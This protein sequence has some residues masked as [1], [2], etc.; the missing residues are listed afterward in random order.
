MNCTINDDDNNNSDELSQ[1]DYL[2]NTYDH[3][4]MLDT[5]DDDTK[6][7]TP[8]RLHLPISNQLDHTCSASTTLHEPLPV[9]MHSLSSGKSDA[10]H[11]RKYPVIF[12]LRSN[13]EQNQ[14]SQRKVVPIHEFTID[15]IRTI[16]ST[17]RHD[18]RNFDFCDDSHSVSSNPSLWNIATQQGTMKQNPWSYPNLDV[19]FYHPD[20]PANHSCDLPRTFVPKKP[21][22]TMHPIMQSP[23]SLQTETKRHRYHRTDSMAVVS[24]IQNNPTV[25]S[26]ANTNKK[27]ATVYSKHKSN[28]RESIAYRA[29]TSNETLLLDVQKLLDTPE[30]AAP[31]NINPLLLPLSPYNYFF[32]DERDNIVHGITNDNNEA[33]LPVPVSDFSD[34]KLQQLLYQHWFI[35]PTKQKRVHRKEHGKIKFERSVIRIV[36]STNGIVIILFLTIFR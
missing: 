14:Y 2:T 8:T 18:D 13:F 36:S 25:S 16:D 23:S 34:S 33:V 26:K 29:T 10:V 12:N 1:W 28:K 4:P 6:F 15:E 19:A 32:R 11:Q 9:D 3:E 7:E 22:V 35:D 27:K 21:M 31:Q 30:M 24:Q 17:Y 5:N 20:S